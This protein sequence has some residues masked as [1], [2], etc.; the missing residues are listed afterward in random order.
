MNS[1]IITHYLKMSYKYRYS[2]KIRLEI[3]KIEIEN[4]KKFLPIIIDS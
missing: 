3:I 1:G 4:Y 2:L